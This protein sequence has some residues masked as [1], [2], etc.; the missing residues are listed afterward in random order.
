[1]DIKKHHGFEFWFA[2]SSFFLSWSIGTLPMHRLSLCFRI[3]SE[4]HDSSHAIPLSK[5]VESVSNV[6]KLFIREAFYSGERILGAIFEHTFLMLKLSC[7]IHRTLSI[8]TISVTAQIVNQWFLQSI[9]VTLIFSCVVGVEGRPE[10][11]SSRPSWN[12][13]YHSEI[14]VRKRHS[15]L[16]TCFSKEWVLFI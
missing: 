9:S 14:W 7:K 13:L 12:R 11:G 15:Y 4:N 8:P 1:M 2:H 3:I 16:Y 5:I 10:C 6:F